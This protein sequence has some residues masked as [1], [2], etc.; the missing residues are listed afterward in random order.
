MARR[1]HRGGNVKA[2]GLVQVK[3][4]FSQTVGA[5][6]AV[7][8]GKRKRLQFR[9][10]IVIDESGSPEA[11]RARATARLV[12]ILAMRDALVDVGRCEEAEYLMRQ[13]AAVADDEEKFQFAIA[14]ANVVMTRPGEK[15]SAAVQ[16]FTTWGQLARAWANQELAKL[17]PNAGYAKGTGETTDKPRVEFFCKYIEHAPLAT[18]NDDDYWRAMRPARQH[19]ETDSTFRAYSQVLR[20]VL[21]I[22]V[23]LQ[24]IAK[25]PLG[26]TCKL[27]IVAKGS[28]PEFPFLYPDEY[29]RLMRCP[30]VAIKYRVLY[31]FIVREGLRIMEAVRIRWE[32][33][34]QMPNGRWL[35][36]VP[37]TKTGRALNFVLNPGTGEVLQAL[38]KLLPEDSEGPFAWLSTSAIKH[39]AKNL[40]RHIQTSGTTRPRLLFNQ[41]RLRR[42]REHDLRST[43]VTWCKLAGIDNET[44]SAHTGHE[45]STMIARYNRSK[46]TIEHLG[47]PPYLP[48]DQALTID[49]RGQLVHGIAERALLGKGGEREKSIAAAYET[50]AAAGEP[51][52][53]TSARQ[54]ERGRRRTRGSAVEHLDPSTFS[55]APGEALCPECEQAMARVRSESGGAGW[56]CPSC[57][58]AG[59]PEGDWL[60]AEGEE[61]SAS[62]ATEC[63]ARLRGETS[64][65]P[66]PGE[67]GGDGVDYAEGEG[68]DLVH[69]HERAEGEESCAD[70]EVPLEVLEAL[71]VA[72]RAQRGARRRGAGARD[73]RGGGFKSL[74]GRPGRGAQAPERAAANRGARDGGRS[75]RDAGRDGASRLLQRASRLD[76]KSS[77]V[78]AGAR[79]GSRTPMPSRALE[80]KSD[81]GRPE[82]ANPEV[83]EVGPAPE[84]TGTGAA[85]HL[86]VTLLEQ[87]QAAAER[88]LADH[89]WEALKA[90]QP[91]IEAEKVRLSNE[92]AARAQPPEP[93]PPVRLEV[94]RSQRKGGAS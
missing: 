60:E 49:A 5:G 33:L 25:W 13:A 4:G 66:E 59:D 9:L 81:P 35:L 16:M 82:G 75:S 24:I 48:L 88:A 20:R 19:T 83:S 7:I 94:V 39:A 92:A 67:P 53:S 89:N 36:D 77:R 18:F 79:G 52:P 55:A 44:I 45:S 40:R 12:D 21:K 11:R 69:P 62:A 57:N 6:S 54:L 80:P 28:G 38:R 29:V 1:E 51:P 84:A 27:P 74:A 72:Y 34:A 46:A 26:A 41:G 30:E 56:S 14:S 70:G 10:K 85:S 90:L 71:R 31:G 50:S 23:E 73:G 32:H 8:D 78:D 2:T 22:A 64:S 61:Y 42:L 87:L 65:E 93:A 15:Q 43:F 86:G 3:G 76:E 37:D 63:N 47:L 68:A 17:Y 91:V 58:A